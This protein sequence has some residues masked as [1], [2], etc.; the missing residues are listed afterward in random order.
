MT[1]EGNISI[2][3]VTE[4][5]GVQGVRRAVEECVRRNPEMEE[6]LRMYASIMEVQQ[7]A[8][9]EFT[10]DI[11]MSRSQ[12]DDRLRMGKPLLERDRVEVHAFKFVEVLAGIARVVEEEAPAGLPCREWLLNWEG[13]GPLGFEETRLAVLGGEELGV[14]KQYAEQEHVVSRILWESLVPFYRKCGSVLQDR[15]DHAVWQR[16]YCPIC[17]SW[18]FMGEFRGGDGLWLVECSLCH[19]LWN[20]QRAGCPFCEEVTG[21]MEYLYIDD[22]DEYRA[23]YCRTCGRYLKTVDLRESEGLVLLPLED[24]VSLQL[25]EAAAREGLVRA[26]E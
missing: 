10:T 24:I 23:Y 20:I 16:G 4:D 18:P 14:E 26:A 22:K 12:I 25:D 15:V 13:V 6:A 21:S 17:G 7:A 9:A 5:P 1:N 19:T 11:H 8:L 2:A 3:I